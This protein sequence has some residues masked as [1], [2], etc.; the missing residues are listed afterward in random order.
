MSNFFKSTFALAGLAIGITN[1]MPTTPNSKSYSLKQS[2]EGQNFFDGFTFF[3]FDDPTAGAVN[4]VDKDTAF[5][6]GL[7]GF[8]GGNPYI[9]FDNWSTLPKGANRDSVRLQSV[10]GWNGGVLIFDVATMPY[11][12]GVS[13]FKIVGPS[14]YPYITSIDMASILE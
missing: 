14:I 3:T 10:N 12:L 13:N 7:A 8:S 4:Y 2:Y 9:Q 5:S 1:S 11:G 6:K